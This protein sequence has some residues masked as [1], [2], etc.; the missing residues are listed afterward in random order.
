MMSFSK[1]LLAFSLSFFMVGAYAVIDSYEFANKEQ[2]Q[3]FFELTNE[4]RCPKCQNQSIGDSNAPIAHDLRREVHK[5]VVEGADNQTVIDFMLSRYG[6]FVLYTP[7]FEGKNLILWLGPVVLL[8]IGIMVFLGVLRS[9]R[10][11]SQNN[12]EQASDELT[13]E[14]REKLNKA[15]SKI[16]NNVQGGKQ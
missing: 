13:P 15:L 1:W 5:M 8:L 12:P 7:R 14:Q 10:A 16:P 6:D 2:E 4:L 11:A 9:H 3:R